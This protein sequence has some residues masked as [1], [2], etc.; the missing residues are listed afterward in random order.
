MF[1]KD[2]TDRM[3]RAMFGQYARHVPAW[4]VIQDM[5]EAGVIIVGAS[6]SQD[7]RYDDNHIH[8]LILGELIVRPHCVIGSNHLVGSGAAG[9]LHADNDLRA[10]AEH[11]TVIC[12]PMG[13]IR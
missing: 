12:D 9:L 10:W 8:Q 11:G 2:E 5:G 13:K 4:V 7:L 3:T 1:D 6:R